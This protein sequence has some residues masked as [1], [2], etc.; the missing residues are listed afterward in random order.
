MKPGRV[1]EQTACGNRFKNWLPGLKD[2]VYDHRYVYDEI[3][4]N[5]RPLEVQATLGLE[6]L[7]KLPE[8]EEAR[9]QNFKKLNNIFQ[10]YEKFFYLPKATK[11]S[12][13]CWFAYLL[14]VKE[15]ALFKKQDIVSYLEKGKIQ[16]RSYFAGNLLTHPGYHH[17]GVEYGDMDE[18]FPNAQLVTT[19]SFFL[20]TFIGI[21]DEKI[22][23]IKKIVDNFFKEIL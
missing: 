10:P 3:G 2:A 11:K 20:G 17:M 9:R 13:P 14:T 4:Y 19:N 1:V 6:Q 16:T 12:D 23:Y 22:N 18:V 8:M 15:D 5:L 21:T 7:K